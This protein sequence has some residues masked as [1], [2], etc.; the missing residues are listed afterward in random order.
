MAVT[1]SRDM[2]SVYGKCRVEHRVKWAHTRYQY[3]CN[4]RPRAVS[5][6]SQAGQRMF[7][8]R[9]KRVLKLA[10]V[11]LLGSHPRAPETFNCRSVAEHW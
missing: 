6:H 4:D 1:W 3:G 5:V 8:F 2:A 9:L 11:N 10:H 7:A